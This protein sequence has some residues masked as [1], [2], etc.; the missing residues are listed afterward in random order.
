MTIDTGAVLVQLR[1]MES[2]PVDAAQAAASQAGA[3]LD[4]LQMPCLS[5]SVPAAVLVH[6]SSSSSE[7]S[8]GDSDTDESVAELESCMNSQ[9][10][11]T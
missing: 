11:S 7:A 4:S 1:K 9:S 6:A 3:I 2:D 5:S 8:K 10:V